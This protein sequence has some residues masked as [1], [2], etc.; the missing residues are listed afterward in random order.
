MP[1][2]ITI[3]RSDTELKVARPRLHKVILLNDDFTPRGF[4]VRIL[5][6]EFRLSDEKARQ[7]MTTA[8]QRGACVVGVF[9]QDIAE[10]KATNAVDAARKEGYPLLLTTEPEE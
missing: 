1:E 8:H 5:K 2:T 9:T 6:Y 4:V 10:T 7:V 3:G